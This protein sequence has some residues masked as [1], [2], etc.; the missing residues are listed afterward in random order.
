MILLVV[1]FL[2]PVTLCQVC[3]PGEDLEQCAKKFVPSKTAFVKNTTCLGTHRDKLGFLGVCTDNSSH[4]QDGA[5]SYS[6]DCG[7]ARICCKDSNEDRNEIL[8]KAQNGWEYDAI[9]VNM[10]ELEYLNKQDCGVSRTS[11]VLGGH[12]APKGSFPFIVSFTQNVSHPKIW[13][14]FCGGVMISSNHVLTAAHCFDNLDNSL[15]D[16]HVRV[17]IGVS[18]LKQKIQNFTEK[19]KTYA[20][21]KKV[22]LHPRFKRNVRGYLNPFNDIAVVELH[23]LRGSHKTV[24]L[25][26]QVDQ[27]KEEGVVAGYGATSVLSNTGPQHLVY[28][29]VKTVQFSECK[30]QYADFVSAIPG[31]VYIGSNVL[32]AGDNTTDAC[33][34]DS[35]SPLLWVD[36]LSRWTVVGVVSFGPS[37][38]GQDVPGAYTK[39]KNY[40][41]FIEN[42]IS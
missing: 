19:R 2:V 21:I 39:V 17:R 22:F 35:G 30:S 3:Y 29:H 26:T 28:A 10:G 42:I 5:Y 13:K 18:D 11:F 31:D 36:D 4:C 15:W 25:P 34:G 9:P 20:K 38:C 6:L 16:Y 1:I 24:C 7:S 27:R 32:C 8:P 37:V 41:D 14:T 33:S 12:K 23:F 40:L